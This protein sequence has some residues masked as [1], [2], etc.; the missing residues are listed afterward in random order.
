MERKARADKILLLGVDGMDPRLTRKYVDAGKMPHMKNYIARGACREDLVMLGGHPTITPPMWTTLACGCYANVHGITDFY[1]KGNDIDDL[2][3]NFDS[4]LCKAEQ[5]WNCFAEAGKKTLVWHWPGS[6]WPP[7]SA[8]ENLL[9]VDGSSPGSVN[10]SV[11]QLDCEFLVGGSTEFTE[12]TYKEKGVVEAKAACVIVDLDLEA[13]QGQ[14]GAFS[15]TAGDEMPQAKSIFYKRSQLG[16]NQTET[17]VD[18]VQTPIK[19]ASGW[20]Q[21]PKEAKEFTVLLSQGLLRRPSLILKNEQGVYDKVAIYKSKKDVEPIVVLPVGVMVAEVRDEAIKRDKRYRVNRNF[22]LL[23]LSE[24]GNHLSLYVSAAMDMDNDSLWH[25]KRLYKEV[26]ENVGYPTP[27]SMLGCQDTLLIRDCMLSNWNV[28]ADWQ[29][30]ALHYLIEKEELEVVFSHFHGIDLQEHMFIK[31]VADRPFN[32]NDVAIAQKWLEDL[33]I[34]TDNYLGEF[35]HFLDEGWTIIIMSDH[36]QVAPKHDIPLLM[37]LNG[38]VTPIME[39][40]GFCTLKVDENGEKLPEFD[41]NK[42]IAVMNG[43]GHIYLNLKGREA[44]G[45]VDPKD[46]YEIEEQIMTAL[47]GYRDKE[48]GHRIVSLALRNKDAVIL[49]LG[50][51]DSGDIIACVAEGYNFDHGDCLSTTLGEGDTSISP[52]FVAAGKGIKEGVYTKRIIR[53]IDFAPTVAF[54]GGVRVPRQCEGAPVY[55]IFAEEI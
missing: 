52:I 10:M 24:D 29:A 11:A 37:D 39:E 16:T 14:G 26:T 6:A 46:Q 7:S 36:A 27:T 22:R 3:Y 42:T 28:T 51:P 9:V 55:Q 38:V 33:Y 40:L 8:N 45:I 4:R 30:K 34:Q 5:L 31:H 32:K 49:G 17:A 50:G 1:R 15:M 54:L 43:A 48:T 35:Y 19:P 21:V 23:N 53:Q 12:V 13:H 18:L 41:W 47:Y 2:D 44:H 25:P 20:K